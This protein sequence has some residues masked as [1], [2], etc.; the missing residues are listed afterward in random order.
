MGLRVAG[1]VP[2]YR[3]LTGRST[4]LLLPDSI[5]MAKGVVL[6]S[7]TSPGQ[8]LPASRRAGSVTLECGLFPGGTVSPRSSEWG[9]CRKH[10]TIPMRYCIA[11][12]G[13]QVFALMCL[14]FFRECHCC[15]V[16]EGVTFH[17]PISKAFI[18]SASLQ[19]TQKSI[20][21]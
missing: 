11:G 12:P 7:R 21:F 20:Y 14:Q 16:S 10:C 4:H 18:G 19:K 1:Q 6:T 8:A 9:A 5:V 13:L 17:S 15:K 2:W 3:D